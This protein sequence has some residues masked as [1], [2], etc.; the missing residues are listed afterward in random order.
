MAD[1]IQA[2]NSPSGF[3]KKFFTTRNIII[4]GVLGI[5]FAILFVAF[6]YIL[7]AGK[8]SIPG[9]DNKSELSQK[10]TVGSESYTIELVEINKSKQGGIASI[11]EIKGKT[12][13]LIEL[14]AV[15]SVRQQPANIYNGACPDPGDS[16]AYILN[17]IEDGSSETILD[18]DLD[19][20][21]SKLPLSIVVHKSEE[22]ANINV[23]CGNLQ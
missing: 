10:T 9:I 7:L 2:Q 16:V 6:Y 14:D 21:R 11:T 19:Q 1:N 18:G 8:S 3:G 4:F 15:L 23:S 20:I 17:D 13:V 22:E 12:S 5:F